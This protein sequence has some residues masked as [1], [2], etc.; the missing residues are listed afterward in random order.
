[1]RS[2]GPELPARLARARERFVWWR[3][4]RAKRT[5]PEEL[6]T[7]AVSLAREYGVWRTARALGLNNHSLGRRLREA[8][9]GRDLRAHEPVAP[10]FLEIL[11]SPASVRATEVRIELEGEGGRKLRLE[12]QGAALGEVGALARRLWEEAR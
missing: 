8:D 2:R 11:P 5:I 10:A 12:L 6:W 4:T 3:A 9:G 1:M 7:L